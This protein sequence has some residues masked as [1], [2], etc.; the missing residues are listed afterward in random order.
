MQEISI[1]IQFEVPP[2]SCDVMFVCLSVC[3]FGTTRESLG[4]IVFHY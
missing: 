4:F 3:V 2:R 1:F